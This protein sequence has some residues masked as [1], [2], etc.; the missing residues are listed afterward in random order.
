ML[1]WLRRKSKNGFTIVETIIIATIIGIFA[2]T[3]IPNLNR[4]RTYSQRDQCIVNMRRIALAKEH[5]S[6]ETAAGDDD[7][8]TSAELYAYIEGG[9]SNLK[10]SLDPNSSFY[11]SYII[12]DMSTDPEC[13][14]PDSTHTLGT[15][16]VV[17]KKKKTGCL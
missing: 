2:A 8:P 17:K 15:V 11:T 6:I 3:V 9:T 13:I 16:V 14:V 1:K 7:T 10:C 4:A 5:W 12:N